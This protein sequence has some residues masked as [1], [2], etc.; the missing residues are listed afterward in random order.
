MKRNVLFSLIPVVLFLFFGCGIAERPLASRIGTWIHTSE[1]FDAVNNE[2]FSD[3]NTII[4][5][6]DNTATGKKG[7]VK[8]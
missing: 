3:V 1:K 5:S 8:F 2:H 6:K 7:F 4:I